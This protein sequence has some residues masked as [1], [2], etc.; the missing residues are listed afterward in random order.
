[1]A[2]WVR[3]QGHTPLAPAPGDPLFDLAWL[4]R[5]VLNVAE[6]KSTTFANEESQLRLGLGQVLRYRQQLS[7]PGREVV[8]WL[9]P[10]REPSDRTWTQVCTGAGVHLSWPALWQDTSIKI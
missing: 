6:V 3:A 7:A 5:D 1:M 10:E 4:S 8:A 2:N 9:V